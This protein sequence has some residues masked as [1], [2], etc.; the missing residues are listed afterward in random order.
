MVP[1]SMQE[2]GGP[3]E[4]ESVEERIL[5]RKSCSIEW[6]VPCERIVISEELDQKKGIFIS[7][8][9]CILTWLYSTIPWPL[10]PV[11]LIKKHR[12]LPFNKFFIVRLRSNCLWQMSKSKSSN[13]KSSAK[14]FKCMEILEK[15]VQ[16]LLLVHTRNQTNSN[17]PFYT[18]RDSKKL[19]WKQ[20][21]VKKKRR[22]ILLWI[23]YGPFIFL[24]SD[25]WDSTR[26]LSSL[27]SVL[28]EDFWSNCNFHNAS[29]SNKALSLLFPF[30]SFQSG[31]LSRNWRNWTRE[32]RI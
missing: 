6:K 19:C 9:S 8:I 16:L 28:T 15:K 11:S 4:S 12:A 27:R 13:P 24:W 29:L 5:L 18:I 1:F 3:L 14:K 7:C 17:L 31:L 23:T 21:K 32:A 25:G 30:S 22:Q 10:L 2:R 26:T 20:S